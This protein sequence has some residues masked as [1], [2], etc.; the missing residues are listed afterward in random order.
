[1]RANE[2][3][4]WLGPDGTRRLLEELQGQKSSGGALALGA[5]AEAFQQ[6][7][8]LDPADIPDT[9]K[10]RLGNVVFLNI[11]GAYGDRDVFYGGL[12]TSTTE[13]LGW[14]AKKR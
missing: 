13:V 11:E 2:V 10:D 5:A 14:E 6:S 1:M 9:E 8:G 3:F 12:M 7:M 4:A